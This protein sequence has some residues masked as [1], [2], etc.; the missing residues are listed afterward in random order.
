MTDPSAA[1]RVRR[2]QNPLASS[3]R[4]DNAPMRQ[5]PSPDLESSE[6]MGMFGAGDILDETRRSVP[7]LGPGSPR[8]SCRG[9]CATRIDPDQEPAVKMPGVRYEWIPSTRAQAAAIAG[10]SAYTAVYMLLTVVSVLIDDLFALY[11]PKSADVVLGIILLVCL[12]AF[13]ADFAINIISMRNK[14]LFSLYCLL[15]VIS[16]VSLVPVVIISFS[17]TGSSGGTLADILSLLRLS[18]AARLSSRAGRLVRLLRTA[19]R[20]SLR[21]VRTRAATPLSLFLDCRAKDTDL[22]EIITVMDVNGDKRVDA[23]EFVAFFQQQ[24]SSDRKGL[25]KQ[26]KENLQRLFRALD[27]DEDGMVT[28]ENLKELY[29]EQLDNMEYVSNLSVRHADSTTRKVIII[30]FTMFCVPILF[31]ELQQVMHGFDSNGRG[32]AAM[33]LFTADDPAAEVRRMRPWFPASDRMLLAAVNGTDYL[34]LRGELERLRDSEI[35]KHSNAPGNQLWFSL[36]GEVEAKAVMSMVETC[37]VIILLVAVNGALISSTEKLLLRPLERMMKLVAELERNPLGKMATYEDKGVCGDEGS[38][39]VGTFKRMG[40]LLQVT[41]GS[42]GAEILSRNVG[43][44]GTVDVMMQGVKMWGVFAFCDIRNFTKITTQLQE[45]CMLFVNQVALVVHRAV[46]A[47]G[48][49]PNKNVGDAFLCTWKRPESGS[50]DEQSDTDESKVDKVEQDLAVNAMISFIVALNSIRASEELAVHA[51]LAGLPAV[52]IGIGLHWGWAIEGAVGSCA[53]VDVTYLSPHVNISARLESATKQFGVSLLMSED[54]FR[55]LR[56]AVQ[57][58]CRPV[59]RVVLVGC[60]APMTLYTHILGALRALAKEKTQNAFS[61]ALAASRRAKARNMQIMRQAI[62]I[63]DADCTPEERERRLSARLPSG[64]PAAVPGA[65]TPP[66]DA[67]QGAAAAGRPAGDSTP[68]L[69]G[70]A[71]SAVGASGPP[72]EAGSGA[73]EGPPTEPRSPALQL[74]DAEEQAAALEQ[75][76]SGAISILANGS[77]LARLRNSVTG[78]GSSAQPDRW[79]RGK[80]RISTVHTQAHLEHWRQIFDLYLSGDWSKAAQDLQEF[81]ARHPSDGPAVALRDTIQRLQDA[82]G[83]APADWRGYRSLDAK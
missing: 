28:I 76:P 49:S 57:A 74:T 64:I 6:G 22:L 2:S 14:Y 29:D 40:R 65:A 79:F 38:F 73:A 50:S 48:G 30:V 33:L 78:Q 46:V 21:D 23:D 66:D 16:F 11:A 12:A 77:S 45:D 69:P 37:Y 81:I 26:E 13:A 4:A 36:R 42:A 9:S 7:S 25:S 55:L 44:T 5:S 70:A 58:K 53:K 41:L 43:T 82:D 35:S 47:Y 62:S 72:P 10:S 54:F 80:L 56:P 67:P 71:A 1:G 60:D 3:P 8:S 52:A 68:Q 39:L 27:D 75:Q 19:L 63:D 31:L 34:R 83:N 20:W 59:D 17:S 61:G 24:Q 32:L 18:R 15:D 51:R